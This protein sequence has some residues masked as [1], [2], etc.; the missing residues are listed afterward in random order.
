MVVHL[1][2]L[3]GTQNVSKANTAALNNFRK[4]TENGQKT[5]I[6]NINS[7]LLFFR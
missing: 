4:A 3:V 5:S 1:V 2:P 7:K 6:I